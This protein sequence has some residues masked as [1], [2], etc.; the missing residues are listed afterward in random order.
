MRAN[1]KTTVVIADVRFVYPHIFEPSAATLADGKKSDPRYKT[2]FIVSKDNSSALDDL[3]NAI[4]EVVSGK[5][6]DAEFDAVQGAIDDVV[7]DGD[8]LHASKKAIGKK[9]DD[10]LLGHYSLN[11]ASQFQPGCAGPDG[12]PILMAAHFYSGCYGH[13]EVTLNPYADD[14]NRLRCSLWL[15]FVMKTR[16]ADK[17]GGGQRS[18]GDVFRNVLPKQSAEDPRNTWKK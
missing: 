11:A 9:A 16:D 15:N 5:F 6:P 3:R 7:K 8:D 18:A 14:K 13:L 10:Y 17:I 12:K 2:R 1:E 4:G